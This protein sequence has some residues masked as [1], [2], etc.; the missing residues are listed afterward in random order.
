MSHANDVIILFY[1]GPDHFTLTLKNFFFG[2][3]VS[4][5]SGVRSRSPKVFALS[6]FV[7]GRIQHLINITAPRKKVWCGIFTVW[8]SILGTSNFWGE[9]GWSQL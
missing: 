5:P 6:M 7:K 8:G 3:A 2:L 1:L 4:S 9:D